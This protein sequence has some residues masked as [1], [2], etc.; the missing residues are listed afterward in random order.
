M[1]TFDWHDFVEKVSLVDRLFRAESEFGAMDFATRDRYRHAVEDLARGSDRSEVAVARQALTLAGGPERRGEDLG[2]Y[3]IS[4]G[5]PSLERALG[6]RVSWRQRLTRA[7]MASATWSYLGIDRDRHLVS[8]VPADPVHARPR[9]EPAPRP[10]PRRACRDSCL[11]RGHRAGESRRRRDLAAA[12]PSE[13]RAGRRRAARAEDP[14]RR[15]DLAL[16]PGADR[17]A[18]R[19]AGRPLSRQ[20]RRRASLRPLVGLDG[21]GGG[22]RPRGRVAAG[23]RACGH[24]RAQPATRPGQ[25]RRGAVRALPPPAP[26]ERERGALDGLGA[27]A[28]QAAR[29]QSAAARRDRHLVHARAGCTCR[30]RFAS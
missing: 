4:K 17:R 20:R 9:C 26:L 29:A 15:A 5:R 22:A 27:Q 10:R 28:R 30:R 23:G 8:S 2:Y 14:R 16:E 13:A 18:D 25:R 19:A 1:A 24:R 11:G 12:R 21:F 3:L 6:Y 7:Y